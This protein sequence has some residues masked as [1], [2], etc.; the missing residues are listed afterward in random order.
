MDVEPWGPVASLIEANARD[1]GLDDV[2]AT[3]G[4]VETAR[5]LVADLVGRCDPD[6]ADDDATVWLELTFE[7]GS[8]DHGFAFGGGKVVATAGRPA[9]SDVRI[10]YPVADLARALL[11][12][13]AAGVRWR[14]E[15]LARW[16][17]APE[18]A[19]VAPLLARRGRAVRAGHALLRA[20]R[21]APATLEDLAVAFGSDKWGGVHW[22]TPHYDRHFAPLRD[23]PVRLLE[24]GV[25]GYDV[26]E[27]GGGS[28]RMWQRY[29]RRGLIHG[30]D[31][32]E[33]RL[34]E[35][36][37]RTI[38]GDQNDPGFL[39][40]LGARIGP[41]DIVIDD[42]SHVNEH[43]LTSFRALFP[44]VRPGGLYVIEDLQTAYWPGYG[45][46]DRDLA[47][48]RTSIG[49]LKSLVDGLNHK[50]YDHGP[51]YEPSYTDAH[52]T[53]VHFYHNIAFIEKGFNDE[54]GP[55]RRPVSSWSD[56]AGGDR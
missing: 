31:I 53:S 50:E 3:I 23:A 11:G 51:G 22:Y 41:L 52:V 9:E 1:G 21:A 19:E 39:S 13:G 43:V 18:P 45:G 56:V 55:A 30:L 42:G 34:A 12:D 40:G 35:P 7:G 37:I 6:P 44:H 46:D 10:S 25:G 36:R 29:F 54:S 28:L 4:P 48:P 32:F 33:K 27:A 47:S 26:P 20:T 16:P 38:R 8:V 5:I 49:L 14:H 2:I 24:I 15:L 17:D